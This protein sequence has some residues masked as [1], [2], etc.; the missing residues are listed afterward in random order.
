MLDITSGLSF[1]GVAQSANDSVSSIQQA[2]LLQPLLHWL[3]LLTGATHKVYSCSWY[4]QKVKSLCL[5]HSRELPALI[6]LPHVTCTATDSV[7]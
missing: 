6:Q 2:L 4:P 3:L 1:I 5:E 7:K